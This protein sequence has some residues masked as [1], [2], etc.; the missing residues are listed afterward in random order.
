MNLLLLFKHLRS[1][2]LLDYHQLFSTLEKKVMTL[3]QNTR[4]EKMG[5]FTVPIGYQND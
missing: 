5:A 2:M 4:K 3:L 1:S